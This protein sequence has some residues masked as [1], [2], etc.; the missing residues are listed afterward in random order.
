MH[1]GLLTVL[2]ILDVL[3]RDFRTLSNLLRC[4]EQI[5][6]YDIFERYS[7]YMYF[8]II[9]FD[10]FLIPGNHKTLK[11]MIVSNITKTRLFKYTENFIKKNETS[12]KKKSDLS[13][14][15]A[16]KIDSE[17]SLEPPQLGGSNEYPQS[18]FLSRNKKNNL[19][20]CKP[21]LLY[22]RGV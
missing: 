20:L 11:E 13:H 18:M 19:Y 7:G 5:V 9:D 4:D 3:P 10:E 6:V 8:G 14:I 2:F 21:V 17:Y 12:D 22:N 15:S 1:P 16:Q